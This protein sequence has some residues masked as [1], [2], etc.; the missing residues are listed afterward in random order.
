MTKVYKNNMKEI[1][2]G[3]HSGLSPTSLAPTKFREIL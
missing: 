1:C 3:G 2:H